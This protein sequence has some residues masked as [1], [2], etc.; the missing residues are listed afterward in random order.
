MD[1]VFFTAYQGYSS[2]KFGQFKAIQARP[3]RILSNSEK[4]R[5]RKEEQEDIR[6]LE[7]MLTGD[8]FD[9]SSRESTP[10]RGPISKELVLPPLVQSKT[11]ERKLKNNRDHAAESRG[12][13]KEAL[14]DH[15]IATVQPNREQIEQVLAGGR[16]VKGKITPAVTE[17][18]EIGRSRIASLTSRI[19]KQAALREVGYVPL[20]AQKL[21]KRKSRKK[22]T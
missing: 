16:R 22:K 2:P 3:R 15:T 9:L 5:I 12:R 6:A 14:K 19:S 1:V 18:S 7:R 8:V 17:D 10:P 11:G 13:Q 20:K 4:D 21:T